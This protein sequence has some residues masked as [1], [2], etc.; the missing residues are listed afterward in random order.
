MSDSLV[1]VRV[2]IAHESLSHSFHSFQD[3]LKKP[4][5]H[6]KKTMAGEM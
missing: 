2:A 6:M 3:S 5:D 4:I 1:S